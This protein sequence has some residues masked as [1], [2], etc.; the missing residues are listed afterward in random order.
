MSP[1]NIQPPSYLS[2]HLK[3]L[4]QIQ[5]PTQNICQS[6]VQSENSPISYYALQNDRISQLDILTPDSQ[7]GSTPQHLSLLQNFNSSSKPSPSNKSQNSHQISQ[8]PSIQPAIT[9][10]SPTGQRYHPYQR[11]NIQSFPVRNL[12][13][14]GPEQYTDEDS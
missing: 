11:H 9:T 12:E 5:P 1:H 4:P 14:Q 10:A 8:S 7:Q 6:S 2:S 13:N 3:P